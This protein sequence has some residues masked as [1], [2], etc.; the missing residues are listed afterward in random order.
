[1]ERTNCTN[2][3]APIN[4]RLVKC[5]YCE[6]PYRFGTDG[7]I[8]LYANNAEIARL[9]KLPEDLNTDIFRGFYQQ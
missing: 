1:M 4:R 6:T 3:G 5:P 9:S 2:C 7:E 8:I